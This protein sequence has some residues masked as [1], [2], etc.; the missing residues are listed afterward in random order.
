MKNRLSPLTIDKLKCYV[1]AL[2]DPRDGQIF[3]IGKGKRSRIYAHVEASEAVET[4]QVDKITTIKAIRAAGLEVEYLIIRHGLEE[5]EAFKIEATLIDYLKNIQGVALT[6]IVDGHHT[7]VEGIK[8]LE[9][10]KIQYDARPLVPQHDLL[11]IRINQAYRRGLSEQELYEATRKHWDVSCARANK[12]PYVCAVYLG[13]VRA[14]YAVQEW[15]ESSEVIGRS[16]FHGVVAPQNIQD[17]YLH[18]DTSHF[19][20]QGGQNPILYT[21]SKI[22]K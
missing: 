3:Y 18:T 22:T 5:V 20:K 19:M 1:Y 7:F 2:I 11:L 12:V 8:K 6:N 10:L 14:V 15:Y 13:V 17:L 9:D 21:E 4:K 16:E